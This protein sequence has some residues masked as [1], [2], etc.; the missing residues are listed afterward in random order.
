MRAE[1]A[2][3][4]MPPTAISTVAAEAVCACELIAY[5]KLIGSGFSVGRASLFQAS[6]PPAIEI[7]FP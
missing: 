3:Q 7:T 6:N 5:S 1:Q 2:A 4:V